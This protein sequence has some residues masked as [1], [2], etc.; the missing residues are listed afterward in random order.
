[1][2][3]PTIQAALRVRGRVMIPV[4]RLAG[5]LAKS[6]LRLPRRTELGCVV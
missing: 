4:A 5:L 6:V 2:I 1:L 3:K